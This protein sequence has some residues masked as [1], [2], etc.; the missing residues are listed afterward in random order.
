MD[1]VDAAGVVED[2]LGE[3]GLAGVDVSGD[4]NVPEAAHGLLPPWLLVFLSAGDVRE[5]AE[6]EVALDESSGFGRGREE[7][8]GEDEA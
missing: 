1:L 3:G 8:G 2:A 5:V 7:G 6:V 4:S